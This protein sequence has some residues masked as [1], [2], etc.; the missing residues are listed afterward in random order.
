[1]P[2]A[3]EAEADPSL[4]PASITDP[5]YQEVQEKLFG[6]YM[7]KERVAELANNVY[8]AHKKTIGMM[9]RFS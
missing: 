2:T 9:A 4:R 6:L 8:K 3:A 7:T 5:S 1:M